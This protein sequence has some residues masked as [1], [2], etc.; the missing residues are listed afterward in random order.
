MIDP[1]QI[2]ESRNLGADCILLIVACLS[3]S[4]IKELSSLSYSLG[5]DVLIEAH[6]VEELEIAITIPDAIIG[7][8]NRNLKTFETDI[9]TSIELRKQIPDSK[10][11]VT[12][13]GIVSSEDIE[14]LRENGINSFLVGEAFM[15]ATRPGDAL[16][17]LFRLAP[18]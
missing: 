18:N 2:I 15:K 8:N 10:L 12:E 14:A 13:S 6:N 5:M 4:Q 7:I 17:K 16:K 9:N 11:L 1:Y 3:I